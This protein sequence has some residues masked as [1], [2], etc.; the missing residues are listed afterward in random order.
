[1]N[2]LMPRGATKAILLLVPNHSLTN[3]L[4]KLAILGAPIKEGPE[5]SYA[6]Q[7]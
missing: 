2:S 5:E 4:S 3:L 7:R 6:P 1:M